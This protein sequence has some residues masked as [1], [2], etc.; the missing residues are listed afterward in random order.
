MRAEH[1]SR[2]LISLLRAASVL[3]S[4]DG[5]TSASELSHILFKEKGECYP[6]INAH[7]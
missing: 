4:E 5:K 7:V 6:G 3:A 1:Q 2:F